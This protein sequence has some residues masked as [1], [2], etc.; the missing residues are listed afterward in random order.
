MPRIT[1]WLWFDMNAE[2]AANFYIGIFP[3]SE[4]GEITR[5]T[6]ESTGGDIPVPPETPMTV[7]FFLDGQ[8]F[9][10]LNG[11]PQFRFSEAVSFQIDC[12]DQEEADHYWYA[13]TADGGEESACGWLKDKY[14]L[15][16]QVVPKRLNE[17]LADP[18]PEVAKRVTA[19]MMKMRRIDVS[20]LEAA[21]R[22]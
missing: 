15:S 2:E 11:G 8:V 22:G 3:N 14:G 19:A 4:I 9:Y 1:P 12:A 7:E 6:E 13:L 17:L 5:Y 20:A 10:G 16:W 21:A 18:D